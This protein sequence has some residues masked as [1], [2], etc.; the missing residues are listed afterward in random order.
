MNPAQEEAIDLN[1]NP[2][3]ISAEDRMLPTLIWNYDEQISAL[4]SRLAEMRSEREDKMQQA[5]KLNCL[6]NKQF[7]I[8]KVEVEG[9]RVA[10]LELLKKRFPPLY[11][12]YVTLRE[13]AIKAESAMKQAKALGE[14]EKKVHLGTADK[15]FGKGN[16]DLCSSKMVT[17]KYVIKKVD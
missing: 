1:K 2:L 13:E 12:A 17:T 3:P 8:E 14:L 4:E 10:D 15:V 7:V 16:V 9:D 5:I 11:R 6:Q